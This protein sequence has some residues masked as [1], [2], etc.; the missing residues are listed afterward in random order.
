MSLMSPKSLE[1]FHP[2]LGLGRLLSS[3]CPRPLAGDVILALCRAATIAAKPANPIAATSIVVICLQKNCNGS[4]N[5]AFAKYG[6]SDW[7]SIQTANKGG[8]EARQRGK[9]ARRL[10][11]RCKGADG[12]G[13]RDR[14]SR[15]QNSH[16]GLRCESEVV[17][18]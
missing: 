13:V 12:V 17:G 1:R 4:L 2:R 16:S 10:R 7:V 9:G 8:K 11:R 5:H 3:L 15:R 14:G 18:G 6:H